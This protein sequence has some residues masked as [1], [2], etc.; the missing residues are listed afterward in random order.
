MLAAYSLDRGLDEFMRTNN[1]VLN[2]EYG[3]Y[4]KL[5]KQCSLL[6]LIVRDT[7]IRQ[8]VK[9]MRIHFQVYF[10]PLIYFR[11]SATMAC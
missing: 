10:W 9:D 5:Y 1:A 4:D 11:V 6:T 8:D 7:A 2:G 3:N